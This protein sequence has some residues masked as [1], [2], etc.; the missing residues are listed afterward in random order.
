MKDKLMIIKLQVIG[1]EGGKCNKT[2]SLRLHD[3]SVYSNPTLRSFFFPPSI[4]PRLGTLFVKTM[5]LVASAEKSVF[6]V[7][8]DWQMHYTPYAHPSKPSL[9]SS[10]AAVDYYHVAYWICIQGEAALCHH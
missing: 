8:L 4:S 1:C 2:N 10:T 5:L 7:T 6:R 3:G 9:Q